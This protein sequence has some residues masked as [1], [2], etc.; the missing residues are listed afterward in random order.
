ME[1]TA[2]S[3]EYHAGVPER[4][5]TDHARAESETMATTTNAEHAA[6]P[7]AAGHRAGRAAR[8]ARL[9]VHQDPLGPLHLL[10]PGRA[11]GRLHRHRRA[12]TGGNRGQL[13]PQPGQQGRVR[14]HPGLADPVLRDRPADHRVLGALAITSEYST[15]MIRTSLTAMPRRG[16]VYAAKAIVF[17]CVTLVCLAD[18]VVRRVLRRPGDGGQHR[19]ERLTVPHRHHPAEREHECPGPGESGRRAAQG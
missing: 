14:R 19:S 1:L 16:V 7:A 12:I 9:G 18:H 10:D 4:S 8:R 11:A 2:S 6:V 17:T 15:G 5:A 3:V 13:Q